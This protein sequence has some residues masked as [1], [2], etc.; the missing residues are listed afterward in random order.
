MSQARIP[1]R[2]PRMQGGAEESQDTAGDHHIR[3]GRL[4]WECLEDQL[5]CQR[6]NGRLGNIWRAGWL[7]DVRKAGWL[8]RPPWP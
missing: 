6:L 4:T 8:W 7:A 3:A 2:R 5:A 1:S